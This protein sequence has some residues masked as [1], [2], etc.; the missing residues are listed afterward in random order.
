LALPMPIQS[1]S[2]RDGKDLSSTLYHDIRERICLLQYPPGMVLREE[3]LA[4]EF[5]VSRTPIRS[6]LQRLEFEG[7]VDISRRTG[8]V[9]TTV[10]LVS[11]KEVYELRLKLMDFIGEMMD[12]D[13]PDEQ[14]AALEALIQQEK[15]G[16]EK[17]DVQAIGKL[18]YRFHT[19][20]TSLISNQ[21]LQKISDL[22]FHQTSRVWLQ[23]LP[24]LSWTKEVDIVF[25]EMTDVLG[26]LRAADMQAVGRI[27]RDHMVRLL[28]RISDYIGSA[29][30]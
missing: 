21:A 2:I 26:A 19:L 9:V 24:K 5:G 11:L 12:P 30:L 1:S 15:G 20:M 14:L 18:Y 25:E 17:R 3:A 10:D 28:K 16:F 6:V 8:A 23:I 13:V 29:S 7:L 27:R 4:A 22:L